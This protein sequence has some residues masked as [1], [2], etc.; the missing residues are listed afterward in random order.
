[1]DN[2]KK[3]AF[4]KKRMHGSSASKQ[5]ES[6]ARMVVASLIGEDG[7]DPEEMKRRGS[8]PELPDGPMDR[9]EI[10]HDETD[11]SNPEERTEVEIA[12]EILG[13]LD[14]DE[15]DIES[16]HEAIRALCQELLDM[17]EVSREDD[18]GPMG[19]PGDGEGEQDGLEE[20]ES[21]LGLDKTK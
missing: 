1:M 17:H 11:L 20:F 3:L 4:L 12:H 21:E 6:K 5:T 18:D 2:K 16:R 14:N 19:G 15:E 10:E 13:K 9:E 8:E 7:F